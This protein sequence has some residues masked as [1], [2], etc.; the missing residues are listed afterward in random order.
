M[1]S[2]ISNLYK[3]IVD[4]ERSLNLFSKK[5]QGT[6]FWQLARFDVFDRLI[7]I[8]FG[9]SNSE[10]ALLSRFDKMKSHIAGGNLRGV[11]E[12]KN[13]ISDLVK[14]L[15]S[16]LNVKRNPLFSFQ[17]DVLFICHPRRVLM[18]D[19][20]WWDI[21]SDFIINELESSIIAIEKHDLLKHRT[22][23]KTDELRYLDVL[24]SLQYLGV[25]SNLAKLRLSK[26]E[27]S[28]LVDI[29]NEL[30]RHFP[31][32]IGVHDIIINTLQKGLFEEPFYSLLLKRIKPK[33]IVLTTSYSHITLNRVAQDMGIPVIELQHGMIGPYHVGYSYPPDMHREV[34]FPDFLFTFG[35]F[36]RDA[37]NFPI[38][39][40]NIVPVGFPY[41]ERQ[42]QNYQLSKERNSIML[43]SQSVVG[44]TIANFAVELS[45]MSEIEEEIIL[46]LHPRDHIGWRERYRE[47]N[48]ST[49]RVIS[50]PKTSIYQLFTKSKAIIG[51]FSTAV[52]EA[53]MFGLDTYAIDAFGVENI[54]HFVDSGVV[55][56]VKSPLEFLEKFGNRQKK[57]IAT[58]M[59]FKRH[60]ARRIARYIESIVNR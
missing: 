6:R 57:P 29:E 48:R 7:Q 12:S 3:G 25:Y 27:R 38:D 35:D 50:N 60:S 4:V 43:V 56:V 11:I 40:E 39:R 10:T 14:F 22:P 13:L 16:P 26:S 33:V 44:S 24:H 53:A 19:G 41:L 20:F 46:K 37:A 51:V 59:Y 31:K 52:F 9:A 5:F 23:A 42:L 55:E 45:K 15:M 47:L 2:S 54:K 36:W 30:N 21:Y 58:E 32:G 28:F 34:T 17:K 49:V 18:S 1:D 8:N